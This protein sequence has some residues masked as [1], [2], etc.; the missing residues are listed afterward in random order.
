LA[1]LVAVAIAVR[2]AADRLM[3]VLPLLVALLV[4]AVVVRRSW[5]GY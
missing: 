4:V 2:V 5:R 1:W 3:P